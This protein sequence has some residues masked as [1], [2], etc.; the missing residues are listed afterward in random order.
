M[1]KIRP[2]HFVDIIRDIGN[3]I[4]D[5]KPNSN[6]NNYHAVAAQILNNKDLL[7]EIT[8][9]PDDV[10]KP[11]RNNAS[12]VCDETIDRS[13]R[14]TAPPLMRD[15]DL[16]INRRWC[17]RLKINPGDRFTA[18]A[19]CRILKDHT[20]NMQAIY[21]EIIDDRIAKKEIAVKKGIAK[22]LGT[23]KM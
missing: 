11:C 22:Y 7:L 8:L 20:D 19:L 14:P 13:F 2:L 18:K 9:D 3:D 21:H 6:G 10:C 17:E 23:K 4:I 1:L 16:S 15:W 5:F 12:G